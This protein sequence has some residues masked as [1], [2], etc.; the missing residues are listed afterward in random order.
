MALCV[1]LCLPW[2]QLHGANIIV[3]F[4]TQKVGPRRQAVL[5][6]IGAV[7]LALMTALLAWRTAVGA[8]SIHEAGETTV[9]LGLP[10]WWTY[11]ILAP[12]LALT[13]FVALI[14]AGLQF[15]GRDLAELKQ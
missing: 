9:I 12:G 14:Q 8:L 15:A 6:A 3:D 1:S 5:D 4:F 7:A 10:M 11:A 2:C 13:C